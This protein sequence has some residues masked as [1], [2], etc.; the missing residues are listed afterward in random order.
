[1]I[2]RQETPDVKDNYNKHC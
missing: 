2:S 1:M